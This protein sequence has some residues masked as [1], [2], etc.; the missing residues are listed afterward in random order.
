MKNLTYL[1]VALLEQV[2]Q[3]LG[4]Y[5]ASVIAFENTSSQ[6]RSFIVCLSHQFLQHHLPLNLVLRMQ[7]QQRPVKWIHIV[8]QKMMLMFVQHLYKKLVDVLR[9]M[10]NCVVPCSQ[11]SIT[12]ITMLKPHYSSDRNWTWCCWDPSWPLYWIVIVSLMVDTNQLNKERCHQV[13][14]IMATKYAKLCTYAFLYGVE[15]K[16]RLEA[17]KKHYLEHGIE[18]RVHKNTWKLP[19]NALSFD[20]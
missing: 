7:E 3:T 8:R 4:S 5:H 15:T 6:C 12:S 19:Y 17:I 2:P 10:E 16:H 13:I 9:L 20:E 1:R 14:C 18:T 11:L